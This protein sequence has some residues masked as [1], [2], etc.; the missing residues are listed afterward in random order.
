MSTP[1]YKSRYELTMRAL[2]RYRKENERLKKEL[3]MA[4]GERDVVTKA[5]IKE[6][7]ENA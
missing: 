1:D 4:R 5:L 6:V 2:E 3:D 7:E